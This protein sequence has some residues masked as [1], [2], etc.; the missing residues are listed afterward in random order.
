MPLESEASGVAGLQA[1]RWCMTMKTSLTPRSLTKVTGQ[2]MQALPSILSL[3]VQGSP[4][5][6]LR[7]SGKIYEWKFLF[8]YILGRC[9][10][11]KTSQFLSRSG[12]KVLHGMGATQYQ[13]EGRTWIT[14]LKI[15]SCSAFWILILCSGKDTDV[16][17]T[18]PGNDRFRY[19]S[20]H[21]IDS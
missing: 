14:F 9:N 7:S 18:S 11:G 15:L 13:M 4:H 21:Y 2:Q 12:N 8:F 5:S 3:Q 1:T 19:M 10:K 16:L 17:T 20:F 6:I